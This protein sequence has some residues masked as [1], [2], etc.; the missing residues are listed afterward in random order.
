MSDF[1]DDPSHEEEEEY[2]SKTQIKR[3][4]E[5]L[6]ELGKKLIG[7]K[8]EMLAK[9]PLSDQLRAALKEAERIRQ[10]EAKRRHLQYIG[11]LM[12][13]VDVE[14]IREHIERQEAGTR[15]YTQ[16]FHQLESWRDKL[17]ADD[18]QI[19][20]FLEAYP[21]G[22]RQHLRQMIRNAAKEAKQNKPPASARKLFKY[23]RELDEN[24]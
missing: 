15:A 3:E 17:L 20:P 21:N 4:M 13:D 23:I 1:F 5:A 9:L 14:L 8:P 22:D 7:Q 12:R 11:K 6:Q 24:S 2:K 18:K 19:D 10:N 16:H